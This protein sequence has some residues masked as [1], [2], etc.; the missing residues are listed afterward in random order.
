VRLQDKA[1]FVIGRK[2]NAV[3]RI[4]ELRTVNMSRCMPELLSSA[5]IHLPFSSI[6]PLFDLH[7]R[8][9]AAQFLDALSGMNY[10]KMIFGL[11]QLPEKGGQTIG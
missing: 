4:L 11:R 9:S 7:S 2:I 5:P 6:K 3:Y 1:P 8:R 10:I